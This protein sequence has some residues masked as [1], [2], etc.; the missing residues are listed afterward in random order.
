MAV[1]RRSLAEQ[2]TTTSEKLERVKREAQKENVRLSRELKQVVCDHQSRISEL[3]EKYE[4]Q[5]R[6]MNGSKDREIRVNV[7]DC[8]FQCLAKGLC[9]V[10]EINKIHDNYGSGWVGPGLTRRKI[11]GKLSQNSPIL[12]LTFWG[13]IPCVF[14]LYTLSKVFSHYDVGVHSQC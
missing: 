2:E 14:C 1:L 12:V 3:E 11:I 10:N 13:C 5:L 7:F 8:R 4:E 9:K 6:E